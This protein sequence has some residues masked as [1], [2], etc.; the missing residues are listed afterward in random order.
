MDFYLLSY[1]TFV[2]NFFKNWIYKYDTC[3]SFDEKWI[4]FRFFDKR[5]AL[6]DEKWIL[7]TFLAELF[8]GML[9]KWKGES[10]K[11][12]QK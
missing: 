6:F 9:F 10:K 1:D 7:F 3:V 5:T 2:C 4:L 8:R 11:S 12:H